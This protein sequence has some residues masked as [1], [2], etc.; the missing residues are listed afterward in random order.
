MTTS[1]RVSIDLRAL[2]AAAEAVIGVEIS[3]GRAAEIVLVSRRAWQRW[4][5]TD[6]TVPR[7]VVQRFCACTGL[8]P[9]AWLPKENQ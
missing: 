8:D 1:S 6:K 3:I 2:R 7:G 9:D 5:H 4:E